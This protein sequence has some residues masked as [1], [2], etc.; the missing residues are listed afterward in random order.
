MP[1]SFNSIP[2][3]VRTPGQ[4][5]EVDNTRAQQG[6]PVI[7]N[8]LLVMSQRLPAGN[9][10]ASVPTRVFS[11]A[12]AE[13]A[14]G[15][16]SLLACMIAA[17]VAVNPRLE[18]WAVGIDDNGAGVAAAGTITFT[19]SPTEAGTL[20]LYLGG[21]RIT[22]ALTVAMTPTQMAAA[23]AAAINAVTSLPVTASA[24][25]GVVTVTFRHK[26]ETGNY[27]DMR[28]NYLFNER[29]P[30]GATVALV[31]LTGGTT[32]PDVAPAIAAVAS[33][34]YHTILHPYTDASNLAKIE[35]ELSNRFGPTV[36]LEGHA[37]TGASGTVGTLTALGL[38]RNHPNQT[39]VGSGKSPS[40]PW[41]FA[42]AAATADAGEADPA[43]PRQTLQL[44]GCLPPIASDQWT[45][46]ERDTLLRSGI[47]TFVVDD[48]GRTLI[49]RLVTTYRT[50]VGGFPDISFLDV[51]TM[52]TLLYLRY[53]VRQ[54]IA[55]RYPRHKLA[56]DGT[57]F[58][59]G[60]AIV[61]PQL[62]RNE[63]TLLFR[64]WEAAG[65]VEGFEQ[66]KADL[67]VERN[68]SDPN[69]IDAVIPPD[70]INQFRVFAAQVQ[71]RL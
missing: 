11:A 42:A 16:G 13:A 56:N 39:I 63:L 24:A 1:L 53:S 25:A 48:G 30:A 38:T 14:F 8:R 37:Y 19:G 57:N 47:A 33:A 34:Q 40:P 17:V 5:L 22:S 41:V 18:L 21:A 23:A 10:L 29:L 70:V 26:G 59:P 71:F 50:N 2:V 51:E 12:Q 46:T 68:G 45:R 9:V 62:I 44:V 32:N 52:R 7:P 6:L 43:K 64:E 58:D 3:D 20:N 36:Q 35:T 27:F 60:Q 69:R 66:F 54:R 61:T 67:I 28:L 55:S 4:F 65:L 15:R 31:Q 49:E